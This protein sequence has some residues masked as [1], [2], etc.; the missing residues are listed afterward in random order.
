VKVSATV[1]RIAT[2]PLLVA[3]TGCRHGHHNPP[4]RAP[5]ASASGSATPPA[6]ASSA[7]P[8]AEWPVNSEEWRLVGAWNDALNHHD[9]KALEALY[10]DRVSFYGQRRTKAEVIRAKQAAFQAEPDFQQQIPGFIDVTRGVG[11]YSVA[12]F[13]KRS[14]QPDHLR[15]TEAKL[16][17]GRGDGGPL[18][19]F[20]EADQAAAGK[21]QAAC[22]AT[23]AEVVN[24]LPEVKR[25]LR[26]A[27]ARVD[28]SNG[29]LRAGGIGPQD[30]DSPD[31]FSASIGIH[32]DESFETV[33]WY[34]VDR[35]GRITVGLEDQ[36][37]IDLPPAA[38]RRV[39]R[40]CRR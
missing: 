6:A 33:I 34:R 39:A 31:E 1:V 15:E 29:K 28:A 17:V 35:E 25:R 37:T 2:I 3:S 4:E 7:P 13:S 12:R 14:G 32:S 9:T 24:A 36:G 40:D 10:A 30:L 23:A 11:D 20:E 19:I 38:L 27:W 21:Q 16:V 26:E 8:A 18:R 22:D 5:R